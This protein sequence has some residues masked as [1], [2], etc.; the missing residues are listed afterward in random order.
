MS[1][2]C[3]GHFDLVLEESCYFFTSVSMIN[4]QK[5]PYFLKYKEQ[6]SKVII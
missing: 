3:F 1:S 6:R 4:S 5:K 2:A